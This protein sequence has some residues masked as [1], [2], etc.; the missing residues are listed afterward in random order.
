MR[1]YAAGR[2]NRDVAWVKCF[3]LGIYFVDIASCGSGLRSSPSSSSSLH[4]ID[5]MSVDAPLV[6]AMSQP[7]KKNHVDCTK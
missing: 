6:S 7:V 1:P 4:L 2:E 3:S 5:F